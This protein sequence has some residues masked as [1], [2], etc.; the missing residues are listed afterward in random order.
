MRGGCFLFFLLG[1]SCNHVLGLKDP[2][3][4]YTKC[5]HQAESCYDQGTDEVTR[6]YPP[7]GEEQGGR[8][9]EAGGNSQDS[10]TGTN[11]CCGGSFT[12][13]LNLSG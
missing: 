2:P 12:L 11:S 10:N 7:V 8:D 4:A 9:D 13:A 6:P 1:E 5:C 3:E